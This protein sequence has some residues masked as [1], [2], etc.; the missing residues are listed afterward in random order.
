[1]NNQSITV[2]TIDN[3]YSKIKHYYDT[4]LNKDKTLVVTSN[5]EPTPLSCVEEMVNKIPEN[6]WKKKTT[7]YIRM[8]INLNNI[9]FAITGI[10]SP[11]GNFVACL[12]LDGFFAKSTRS[13]FPY[14]GWRR[15]ENWSWSRLRDTG[16]RV[17]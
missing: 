15:S 10:F 17:S 16:R 2:L 11:G 1:M 4:V 14:F 12:L 3:D 13:W 6:F 9:F 8:K 7:E 5:D